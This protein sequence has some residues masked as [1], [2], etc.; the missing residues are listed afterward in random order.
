MLF[1]VERIKIYLLS[2]G[3]LSNLTRTRARVSMPEWNCREWAFRNES[4][5]GELQEIKLGKIDRRNYL[6]NEQDID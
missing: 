3:N 2:E 1:H 6:K 5:E 4:I